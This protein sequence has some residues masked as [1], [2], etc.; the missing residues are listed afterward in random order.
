MIEQVVIFAAGRGTRM[1]EFSRHRPKQLIEVLSRPFLYYLLCNLRQAGFAK[2]IMITGYLSAQMEKFF[3]DYKIEF[4]QLSLINQFELLG[5]EKYGTLMPLLATQAAV[6]QDNFVVV[7]GDNLYAPADLVNFR[8]RTDGK[9]YL[10][11]WPVPDPEN[12]GT[13]TIN[14]DNFLQS[15][16]ERSSQPTSQLINAGIYTFTPE[17]FSVVDKVSR[18]PRGEYEITDAIN[19]L[20]AAGQVKVEQLKNYWLDFGRPGDI[21]KFEQFI[22]TNDLFATYGLSDFG[23]SK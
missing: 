15:I 8:S 17:I 18:S 13:L 14:S 4:P 21:G 19:L 20:A 23:G 7:M 9:C 22:K 6:S 11:A 3:Q 2:L 5:E 10:G 1:G 16:E 12:Y